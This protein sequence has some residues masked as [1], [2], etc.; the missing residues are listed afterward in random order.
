MKV[1]IYF[2]IIFFVNFVMDGFVLLLVNSILRLHTKWWRIVLGGMVGAVSILFFVLNPLMWNPFWGTML[3]IGISMGACIVCF[4]CKRKGS[5]MIW[6][7]STT[8]MILI[9]S[10]MNYIRYLLGITSFNL[11]KWILCFSAV[12]VM[13]SGVGKYVLT[14][15]KTRKH[16]YVV[17]LR[18]NDK[19]SLEHLYLDTGNFLWDPL[20]QKPVVLISEKVVRE[21]FTVEENRL[22]R[23]Y[24]EKGILNYI[25]LHSNEMQMK[26]CFH[27]ISYESVGNPSG[28]LLCFLMDE[29]ELMDCKRILYKQP[30][31]VAPESLFK[32]KPYQGLL[33]PDC[34]SL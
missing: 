20:F 14:G 21:C 1:T 8:V 13:V 29:V 31:A 19:I 33:Q 23:E 12:S 15:L 34:I 3:Y 28:R 11:A 27:E 18:H 16:I 5:V 2:D 7:L 25:R 6:L 10:G 22:L 32:G 26:S 4:G 24:F 17:K 9:G 30:V